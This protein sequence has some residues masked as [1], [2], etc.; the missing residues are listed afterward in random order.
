M[1]KI[2]ILLADDHK[3]MR[4][5]LLSLIAGESDMECVGEAGNG[6]QAVSLARQL[7]PDVIVMDLMMP[8][9]SGAEA[10]KVIHAEL[11]DT[12]IVIL[13]SY[14]TAQ[15]LAEAIRSGANGAILKDVETDKL[16]SIIRRICAG[17]TFIP[18]QLKG[19]IREN[20]QLPDFTDHQLQILSSL[21]IGRS[22]A[23]IAT[24]FGISENTVKHLITTILSKLGAT[25]RAEAG[26][27]AL[28]KQLVKM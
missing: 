14:G 7:K 17:K 21:A 3:L 15:E 23:E 9:L 10:T 12:R 18:A 1:K 8:K 2:R 27:I 16:A 26:A 25:T 6:Q 13:T 28:C 24:E 4:L 5:G 20:D 11:P 19:I 22:N